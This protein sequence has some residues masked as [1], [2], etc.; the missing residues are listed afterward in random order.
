MKLAT[1]CYVR[2]N[3]KTLMVHRVKKLND[4][5]QGKWNGLGGKLES[6]ETPEACAARE[7]YEES[8]L[9]VHDL[10]FKG[11][12]TFPAFAKEEDWYAF[13]FVATQFEGELID[14]P[15]GNLAWIE[16]HRLLDLEL[17]EGDRIFLRWLDHPGFFS[18]RFSYAE[19]QLVDHNVIFYP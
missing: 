18:A 1:L 15:E 8:G 7:I 17:W 16:D 10:Q 19:G 14:S 13:V 12:L 9:Q 6:G 4:M 2:N 11:L 5:H 3:G